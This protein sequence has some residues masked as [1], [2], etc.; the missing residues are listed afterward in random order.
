[1]LA[2]F[3]QI[4]QEGGPKMTKI[5]PSAVMDE[6]KL[7]LQI[8]LLHLHRKKEDAQKMLKVTQEHLW[9]R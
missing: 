6:E 2:I 7:G 3:K 8:S 5:P 9:V 1:M 4:E